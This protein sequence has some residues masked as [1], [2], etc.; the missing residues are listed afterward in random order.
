MLQGGLLGES[1][2]VPDFMEF[3]KHLM[4]LAL[5]DPGTPNS[6]EVSSKFSHH[7]CTQCIKKIQL[8]NYSFS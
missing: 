8:Y 3:V 2:Y 5:D 1:E 4:R 7:L 6:K